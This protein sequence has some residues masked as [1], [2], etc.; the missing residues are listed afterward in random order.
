MSWLS[1]VFLVVAAG[2]VPAAAQPCAPERP[3]DARGIYVP[4]GTVTMGSMDFYP[5]ERPLR[6]AKT[7]AFWM[8]AT[9]VTNA[10]FTAFVAA[11]GYV[12]QAERVP[13]AA[14]NPG[15]PKEM[16]VPGAAVFSPPSRPVDLRQPHLWWKF[17]P[18]ASWR[19]PEGPGSSIKGRGQ[20]PVTQIVYE[21]ALAYARWKGRD[22][23]SEAEWERAARGGKEGLAYIWGNQPALDGRTMANSY[24][25]LFP[26][27]DT[28]DDG[29]KGIA[30]VGC[31][32]PNAFGLYDMAG[33]VW[34]WTHDTHPQK[35][36]DFGIIKGGSFLCSLSFCGRF[37]PAARH[38]GDRTLGSNHIGFRTILRERGGAAAPR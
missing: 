6:Q 16:L 7:Q 1:A 29:H 35:P 38:P 9:E 22:L 30:P 37:R 25:G 11:T 28:G 34:E 24:Q 27:K 31:Y 15:V 3:K 17:V 14:G 23:P 36:G 5:E 33:N 10:Q 20:E 32:P 19:Q 12:T 2:S 26:F 8:D 13:K 4:A 18:G 21:D